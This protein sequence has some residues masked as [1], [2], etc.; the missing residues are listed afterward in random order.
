MLS[1]WN[2]AELLTQSLTHQGPQVGR[3]GQGTNKSIM[4]PSWGW[5]GRGSWTG[6]GSSRSSWLLTPHDFLP[7]SNWAYILDYVT[8]ERQGTQ[9]QQEMQA[10]LKQKGAH[11]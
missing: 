4:K 11:P 3:G 6:A 8:G 9:I 10:A 1:T 5:K 2:L 7:S